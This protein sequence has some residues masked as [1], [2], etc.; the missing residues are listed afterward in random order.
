[1]K[2]TRNADSDQDLAAHAAAG[3]GRA[4]KVILRSRCK[5]P[6]K[7][8]VETPT[9]ENPPPVYKRKKRSRNR[10]RKR[11]AKT[12]QRIRSAPDQPTDDRRA[13]PNRNWAA[14]TAPAA[15]ATRRISSVHR[16]RRY[17]Q[18]ALS[19]A[20]A[21]ERVAS[22]AGRISSAR[23]SRAVISRGAISSVRRSRAVTSS[24][25][26]WQGSRRAGRVPQALAQLRLPQQA[27]KSA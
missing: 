22:S 2:F 10:R 5:E 26:R 14:I 13:R 18:Q 15:T 19:T 7:S 16:T 23:R 1:M 6:R 17:Q 11:R 25:R 4:R 3:G 27:E 20:P 9:Q 8:R 21:A 12:E 24:A